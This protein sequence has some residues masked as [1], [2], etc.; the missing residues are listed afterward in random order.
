MSL[1]CNNDDLFEIINNDLLCII[2][3]YIVSVSSKFPFLPVVLV[4]VFVLIFSFQFSG[5][6]LS[7]LVIDL[8]DSHV[9]DKWIQI[10]S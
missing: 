2:S 5:G 8:L 6:P 4:S 1:Y 3:L 9:C 10:M 7:G